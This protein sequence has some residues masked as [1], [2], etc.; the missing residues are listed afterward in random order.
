[1]RGFARCLLTWQRF[2]RQSEHMRAELRCVTVTIFGRSRS[3]RICAN[4]HKRR[5]AAMHF[6]GGRCLAAVLALVALP[7]LLAVARAAVGSAAAAASVAPQARTIPCSLPGARGARLRQRRQYLVLP[8]VPQHREQHAIRCRRADLGAQPSQQQAA[9]DASAGGNGT[10][11]TQPSTAQLAN[12]TGGAQNDAAPLVSARCR[13]TSEREY[14]HMLAH[15][16]Q[17]IK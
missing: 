6:S 7:I 9:R 3:R 10:A 4:R 16:R 5:P 12:C 8:P 14:V 17:C 11:Q 1:M 2:H 13:C 15:G